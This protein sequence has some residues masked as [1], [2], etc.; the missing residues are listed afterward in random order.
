MMPTMEC[1][2]SHIP[3]EHTATTGRISKIDE[4]R[5]SDTS[6]NI[7]LMDS[8]S[9]KASPQRRRQN[10]RNRSPLSFDKSVLANKPAKLDEECDT[11][12]S[13]NIN[14]MDSHSDNTGLQR[15]RQNRRKH[16]AISFDNSKSPNKPV[17]GILKRTSTS[18]PMNS[19]HCDRFSCALESL[20]SERT[21]SKRVSFSDLKICRWDSYG[22]NLNRRTTSDAHLVSK[23]TLPTKPGGNYR[24]E[25]KADKNCKPSNNARLQLHVQGLLERNTTIEVTLPAYNFQAPI[26]PDRRR[27]NEKNQFEAPIKPG[28]RESA[29]ESQNGKCKTQSNAANIF[30][31]TVNDFQS[32]MVETLSTS[33]LDG[34]L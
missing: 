3:N 12:K 17:K 22:S 30:Q 27:S 9:Q 26:K 21:I 7:N 2:P 20:E 24:W 15:R 10:R 18:L 8:H 5:D 11:D 31:A 16:R 19:E 29:A 32:A 33:S 1:L 14:H 4:E 28:R 34:L 6:R 25:S 13:R 23:D